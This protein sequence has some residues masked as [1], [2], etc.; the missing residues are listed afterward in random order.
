MK[1]IA[2]GFTLVEVLVTVAIIGIVTAVALPS[3]SAHVMRGRVSEA[4]GAL[5]GVQINAEQFWSNSRTYIGFDGAAAAGGRMPGN[6]TNFTYALSNATVSTY[7]VTATGIGPAT[8]FVY[9]INQSG[10]KAT[11]GVPAT[12]GWTANG[13]CWVDRKGGACT[14]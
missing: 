11:T 2:Q 10:A 1:R 14:Q 3:Y 9:T 13:A 7:T 5:G 8:G 6:T 4:F 12:G